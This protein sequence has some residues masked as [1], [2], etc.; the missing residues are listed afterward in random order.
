MARS[1]RFSVGSL[2][3]RSWIVVSAGLVS[4]MVWCAGCIDMNEVRQFR[5]NAAHL[6]DDLKGQSQA[7]EQKLAGLAP[8]DPARR[9]VEAALARAKAKEAAAD[10]AVKQV[11]L[12]VS[13]TAHPDTPLGQAIDWAT[14]WLPEPVRVPLALGAA[15]A[16][17]L[18]RA[19]QLK[20]G[21]TSIADGLNKA[22]Q[23]DPEFKAQF[24]RH[25]NTFRAIQT[26]TARKVVDQTQRRRAARTPA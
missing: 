21:M 9:D 8:D 10:A 26:P 15:L 1:M 7:L 6:R 4:A 16:A 23:D 25:A 22:M 14:P 20:K 13:Q 19:S 3:S 18:A 11:D 2:V 12:V 5:D 24:K 17:S